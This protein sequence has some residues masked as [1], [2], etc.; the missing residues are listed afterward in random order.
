MNI[1]I[2]LEKEIENIANKELKKHSHLIN[3]ELIQIIRKAIINK[4]KNTYEEELTFSQLQALFQKVSVYIDSLFKNH[5]PYSDIFK[6]TK[7]D[8]FKPVQMFCEQQNS[9]FTK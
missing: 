1:Q 9:R 6:H 5:T 4:F 3:D 7:V 2:D 8:I